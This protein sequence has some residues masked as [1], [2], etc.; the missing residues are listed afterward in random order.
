[1]PTGGKITTA[2]LDAI[3]DRTMKA[4]H[5]DESRWADAIQAHKET[6]GSCEDVSGAPTD[7][8]DQL[9]RCAERGRAQEPVLNAAHDGMADWTKHLGEMRRSMKGKLHNPCLLYTSPSPRDR[10]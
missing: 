6:S 2:E 5:R 10:S 9:A 7:V 1:M 4:G 3:F 8:A